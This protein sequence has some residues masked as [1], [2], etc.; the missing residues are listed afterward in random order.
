MLGTVE[1]EQLK[2]DLILPWVILGIMLAMLVAT[3][4]VMVLIRKS[5]KGIEG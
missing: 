1:H 2:S 5:K 4:I 3:I